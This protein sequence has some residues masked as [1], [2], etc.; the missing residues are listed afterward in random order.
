MILDKVAP[1]HVDP[2]ELQHLIS[3]STG[4]IDAYIIEC[5]EHDPMLIP[6]NIVLSAQNTRLPAKTVVWHDV[7][8][9]VYAVNSPTLKDGIALIIE[10]DEIQ[11]RFALVCD[12]MPESVRLR[13]SEVVDDDVH[14]EAENNVFQYV[15][16]Q[17]KRYFI[18]NLDAIQT[19][20]GL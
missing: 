7:S 18:P 16:S 6:Q 1:Q 15:Y 12:R 9:A 2:K 5:H 20:L 11:Q 14:I 13:I 17:G 3:V 8:L 19:Q 10:G 4:F